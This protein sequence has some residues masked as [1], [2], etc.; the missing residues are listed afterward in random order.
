MALRGVPSEKD[1]LDFSD[2]EWS[3]RDIAVGTNIKLASI[4]GV[5]QSS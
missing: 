3:E 4:L 2:F 1:S 5:K